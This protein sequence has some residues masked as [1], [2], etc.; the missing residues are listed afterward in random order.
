MNIKKN[1]LK[2]IVVFFPKDSE[3]VFN[4][5]STRTFGGATIQ[6][7][8][9]A[10][11]LAKYSADI[12]TTSIIPA[13][14]EI[15]FNE[16]ENFNLVMA[17]HESDN[18]IQKM[19]KNI[20]VLSSLK[21]DVIIQHGLT[22]PSVFLSIYC[23]IK[24]IKYVFMF[25]H[26]VEARG[27]YQKNNKRCWFFSQL[28]KY[29]P[30]MIV[31]NEYQLT[32]LNNTYKRF[33]SKFFLL[34]NGFPFKEKRTAPKRS[35][36]WV[37]RCEKWKRPELFIELAKRNRDRDFVMICPSTNDTVY[38]EQLKKEAS[39]I[40]N[41]EF[42]EFVPFDKIDAYFRNA[43]LLINTSEHEGYP[44]VF[45]QAAM[46]SVPIIS[47]KVDPDTVISRYECGMVCG[48]D[49]EKLHTGIN[50]VLSD[51]G[52]YKNLSDNIYNFYQDKHSIEKN[53]VKLL[54]KVNQIDGA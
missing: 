49:F 8:L 5:N 21:P 22:L 2:K 52:L 39:R 19:I 37:A 51:N 15:K 17:Y 1:T 4:E 53:V 16:S 25:A 10:Q 47:L 29:T 20:S 7:F 54:E 40:A 18:I 9:F 35:L 3:S 32:T 6:M 23:Y 11:E 38:Y 48:D 43:G 28:L 46:N 42:I 31:Q 24:K 44:Q 13:Y 26:D 36:L 14:N 33:S 30:L 45:I 27:R 12:H 41:L 34:Y 50:R